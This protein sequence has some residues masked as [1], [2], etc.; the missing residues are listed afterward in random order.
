[1]GIHLSMVRKED[2]T[3]KRGFEGCSRSNDGGSEDV[4][5]LRDSK[6]YN[7]YGL[8]RLNVNGNPMFRTTGSKSR[9]VHGP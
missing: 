4:K 1:M 6:A 3:G 2:Q 9:T 8:E 7:I 5:Q